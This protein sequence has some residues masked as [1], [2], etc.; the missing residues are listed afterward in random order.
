MSEKKTV[1]KREQNKQEKLARIMQAA[2]EVFTEQ[3]FDNA[4]TREIAARANVSVGSVFV[5]GH[6]KHELLLMIV[7]QQLDALLEKEISELSV[8]APFIDH[9]MHIIKRRY[10]YW[11]KNPELARASIR[12]YYRDP[13]DRGPEAEK[14]AQRTQKLHVI[15]VDILK[16]KQKSKNLK[17][18]TKPDVIVEICIDFYTSSFS[19]WLQTRK[20]D[21]RKG[22]ETLKQRLVPVL[23]GLGV[24]IDD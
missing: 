22:C 24:N 7:N 13:F 21:V 10:I 14:F 4:T 19:R 15:F 18:K 20:M 12:E 8:E 17:L 16:N 23:E 2:K 11:N 1:T 3:G 6:D 5:H 9:F